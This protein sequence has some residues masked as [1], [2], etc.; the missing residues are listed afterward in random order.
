MSTN[1]PVTSPSTIIGPKARLL[2]EFISNTVESVNCASRIVLK[3]CQGTER[4][5]T[6][7]DEITTVMLSQQ[8][9]RLLSEYDH[10]I[11][12]ITA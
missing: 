2:P 9:Q 3:A 11:K 12:T 4:A 7:I 6:G 1:Q 5:V 8:R 10:S